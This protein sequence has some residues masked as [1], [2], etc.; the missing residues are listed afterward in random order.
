M[1]ST[2]IITILLKA[3]YHN[4]TLPAKGTRALQDKRFPKALAW[5]VFQ[6]NANA[7]KVYRLRGNNSGNSSSKF[8]VRFSYKR[9]KEKKKM[10]KIY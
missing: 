9:F 7:S 10:D 1:Y 2:I 6:A 8:S 5:I 4:T 3:Y